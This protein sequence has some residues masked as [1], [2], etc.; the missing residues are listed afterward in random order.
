MSAGAAT[1]AVDPVTVGSAPR[2]KRRK[3]QAGEAQQG[4][5]APTNPSGG[6]DVWIPGKARWCKFPRAASGVFCGHHNRER[7]P[8]T[9]NPR[10][11]VRREELE[12]HVLICQD[13]HM[14]PPE[15]EPW[16]RSGCNQG[17]APQPPAAAAAAA[18]EAWSGL[19]TARRW[20]ASPAS[21]IPTRVLSWPPPAAGPAPAPAAPAAGGSRAE[22]GEAQCAQGAAK[23]TLQI[24]SLLG[25]L[26]AIGALPYRSGTGDA[27]TMR[28]GQAA[29]AAAGAP[30]RMEAASGCDRPDGP[31]RLY[32]EFGAGKGSLALAVARVLHGEGGAPPADPAPGPAAHCSRIALIDRSNFRR[33]CSHPAFERHRVDLRDLHLAG[34]PGADLEGGVVGF[35][36]HLCGCATD[37]TLRAAAGAAERVRAV[38]I[39]LCCHQLCTWGDYV[40]HQHLAEHGVDSEERFRELRQ[41]TSWAVDG[42]EPGPRELAEGVSDAAE[43]RALGRAAKR[44]LDAGRVRFMRE[45]GFR[46]ELLHYATE[47][48]TPEN[49]LLVCVRDS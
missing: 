23:H 1:P 7:V 35:S 45:H 6:C 14:L 11:T 9:V 18:G 34:L 38:V 49:C 8:C 48:Q 19:G 47:Q 37:Y 36:K 12:Q 10:H 29:A 30:P 5:P 3:G 17:V 33:K 41:L 39:A 20:L 28:H 40:H 43:R 42:R 27:V 46:A 26:H 32:V 25:H 24:A 15:G 22:A 16:Y 21:S 2:A 44:I 4:Q 31:P 13:R